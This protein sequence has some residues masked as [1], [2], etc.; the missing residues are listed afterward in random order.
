MYFKQGCLL[1]DWSVS[2]FPVKEID[3]RRKRRNPGASQ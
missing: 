2:Q 1:C 3:R